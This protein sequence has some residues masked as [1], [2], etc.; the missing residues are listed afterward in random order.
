MSIQYLCL[1]SS[2]HENFD[3]IKRVLFLGKV[4][5]LLVPF[6]AAKFY[7]NQSFWQY[8]FHHY[9]TCLLSILMRGKYQN[10]LH[11]WYQKCSIEIS[12]KHWYTSF[13][14]IERWIVVANVREAIY[15]WNERNYCDDFGQAKSTETVH[16]TM[17][18][19]KIRDVFIRPRRTSMGKGGAWVH[20]HW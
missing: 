19:R 12:L 14:I 3:K 7:D 17:E 5:C 6:R 16:F 13:P 1:V 18:G 20:T 8:S 11:S 9:I 4:V 15:F 10:T 2:G